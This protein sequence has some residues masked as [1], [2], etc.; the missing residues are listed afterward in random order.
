MMANM[1]DLIIVPEPHAVEVVDDIV[2]STK[3]NVRRFGKYGRKRKD[4]AALPSNKQKKPSHSADILPR[5]Y[6]FVKAE[7]TKASLSAL[8][9]NH[10]YH[11]TGKSVQARPMKERACHEHV[12]RFLDND[13]IGIDPQRSG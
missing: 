11:R 6:G 9:Q 2:N 1:G 12:E 3:S 4:D 13:C 8:D 10:C 7:T 5:Y